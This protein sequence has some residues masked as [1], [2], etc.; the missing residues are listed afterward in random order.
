MAKSSSKE[1]IPVNKGHFNLDTEERNQAFN[2]KRAIG[3]EK[4]YAEYRKAWDENPGKKIIGPYPVQVDLELSS[5][6][7]LKCPMCYTTTGKFKEMVAKTYLDF[8]LYKRIIDEV[9]GK[10]YALRLSWRGESSLHNNFI[11]A[12]A[13]AKERGIK[14]I[15]FLTNGSNLTLDSFKE[16]VSAGAT[17]ITVS[18]DGL[19]EE[20]NKVRKPLKYEDTLAVLRS[21]KS[22]KEQNNIAT[23]VIKVQGVWPAIRC[24]PEEYYNTMVACSDLVAFNPIIDYLGND[25]PDDIV[26]EDGFSCP[27]LYE[28]LFVAAN[29]DV[30]MCNSD[31]FGEHIIGNAY[32]Q[33]ISE[34]WHSP[35]L[36][37]VRETH[38]KRDGF[39]EIPIC[40]RCFYPRKTEVNESAEVNGRTILIENYI[41]RKQSIGV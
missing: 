16:I 6:C 19:G 2:A 12:I 36:Q 34:I 30:M 22:Y 26:F 8:D 4:E 32:K 27:Q 28:R 7:N 10:I 15:S 31:E 20:Y 35:E 5:A 40:R 38:N 18:F 17:W 3:W 29:G 33:K 14:E 37:A 13:Y 11:E 9:A 39:L 21:I 41:N 1:Y 25:S 23:P 24:D